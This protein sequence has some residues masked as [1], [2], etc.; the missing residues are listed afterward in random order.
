MIDRAE[1]TRQ[2]R[3][4]Y[5]SSGGSQN[6]Y[7]SGWGGGLNLG[8]ILGGGN[9]F[10][11]GDRAD[12]TRA[13][14]QAYWQNGGYP[15]AGDDYGFGYSSDY[16]HHH[17]HRYGQGGG[18]FGGLIGMISDL[19]SGFGSHRQDRYDDQPYDRAA[20]S[21]QFHRRDANGD[22]ILPENGIP[23]EV[24]ARARAAGHGE[25]H[26]RGKVD[27]D[28]RPSSQYGGMSKREHER[29]FEHPLG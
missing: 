27:P 8:S 17:H 2:R 9:M 18:L 25:V 14:R 28:D 26:Y 24:R 7:S 4:Q 3:A 11:Y 13:R 12:R 6:G 21:E 22:V 16:H 23:H 29:I 1:R 20:G 15:G 19:F 5:W 10:G